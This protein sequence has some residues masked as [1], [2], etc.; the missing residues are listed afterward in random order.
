[1]VMTGVRAAR[2]RAPLHHLHHAWLLPP[3]PLVH[4]RGVHHVPAGVGS[5]DHHPGLL[6]R[7]GSRRFPLTHPTPDHFAHAQGGRRPR[8]CFH[9]CHLIHVLHNLR[10][11]SEGGA[12][13]G[14]VGN[15]PRRSRP[16]IPIC[17]GWSFFARVEWPRARRAFLFPLS[18][19]LPISGTACPLLPSSLAPFRVVAP[20]P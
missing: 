4:R 13:A 3:G 6:V 14:P 12:G 5:A 20:G 10:S 1:M 9:A 2:L 19:C 7:E 16:L 17:F 18:S 8:L 11:P 15:C